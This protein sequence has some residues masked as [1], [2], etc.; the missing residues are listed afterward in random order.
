MDSISEQAALD[1]AELFRSLGDVSRVRII[2]AL[3]ANELTVGDL[4]LVANISESAAS[5]Q[6]RGLRQM[7]LVR[8]RRDGRYVYYRLDDDH[9]IDL[10][11]QGLEHVEHRNEFGVGSDEDREPG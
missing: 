7:R 4:A 10:F 3:A 2:A 5:H 1:L 6:L 9:V 8:P 11:R